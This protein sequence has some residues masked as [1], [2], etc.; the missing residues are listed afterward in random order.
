ME[1]ILNKT[2]GINGIDRISFKKIIEILGRASKIKLE[3][4]KDNFDF[5][6][7]KQNCNSNI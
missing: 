7:V 6:L 4:G 5:V 2:L 3:L 1:F